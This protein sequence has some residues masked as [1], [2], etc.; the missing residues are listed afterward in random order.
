MVGTFGYYYFFA[1]VTDQCVHTLGAISQLLHEAEIGNSAIFATMPGN[2]AYIVNNLFWL[3]GRLPIE[4]DD[5]TIRSAVRM[6]GAFH[7]EK[8]TQSNNID[9]ESH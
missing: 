6:R 9:R 3:H 5:S 7:N 1:F 4:C 8:E 2:T